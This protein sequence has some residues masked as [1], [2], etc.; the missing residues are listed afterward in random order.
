MVLVFGACSADDD[1]LVADQ[2]LEGA[3]GEGAS[4][5]RFGLMVITVDNTAPGARL[6]GNAWFV[7]H[8]EGRRDD[9]VKLLEPFVFGG[10]GWLLRPPGAPLNNACSR[11]DAAVGMGTFG[12]AGPVYFMDAGELT[13][14]S[15]AGALAFQS[16]YFP[17]VDPDIGGLV[18]DTEA[19]GARSLVSQPFMRFVGSGASQVG[20]FRAEIRPPAALRLTRVGDVRLTSMLRPLSVPKAFDEALTVRWASARPVGDETSP[21]H[22]FVRLVRQGFD[23]VTSVTCQVPDTGRFDIPVDVLGALTHVSDDPIDRVEV[24]RAY[25]VE[26]DAEGLDWGLAVMVSRDTILLN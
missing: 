26:F 12:E 7:E 10:A 24:V 13:V 8:D 21:S 22:V 25:T 15:P 6:V 14:E 2:V 11:E 1:G 18:Y 17:D 20:M 4:L 16:G 5:D 9:V 3:W 19:D 23:R